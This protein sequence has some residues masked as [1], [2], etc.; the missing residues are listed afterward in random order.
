MSFL[1]KKKTTFD[2]TRQK[3]FDKRVDKYMITLKGGTIYYNGIQK[4]ITYFPNAKFNDIEYIK[5]LSHQK[6]PY[7]VFKLCW[8][9]YVQDIH[10]KD[11]VRIHIEREQ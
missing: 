11:I 2:I 10:N 8:G 5:I 1:T 4:V 6:T 9:L 7:K 3:W